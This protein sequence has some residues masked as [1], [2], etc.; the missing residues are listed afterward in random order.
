MTA[1][2]PRRTQVLII[3]DVDPQQQVAAGRERAM[4][5]GE[6]YRHVLR[7]R[8]VRGEPS[9]DAA[10]LTV[11]EVQRGHRAHGEPQARIGLSGQLD[12]FGDRSTPNADPGGLDGPAGGAV[13]P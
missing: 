7:Q 9:Q 3:P 8:V 6:H 5:L 1:V 4:E 2:R 11:P 10:E 12:H 13:R